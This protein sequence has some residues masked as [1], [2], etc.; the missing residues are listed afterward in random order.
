MEV[1]LRLRILRFSARAEIDPG[2]RRLHEAH[3]HDQLASRINTAAGQPSVG[4]RQV[5]VRVWV[6]SLRRLRSCM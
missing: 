1:V 6:S 3:L 5:F 2:I 4:E